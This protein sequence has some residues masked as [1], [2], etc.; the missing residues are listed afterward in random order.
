MLFKMYASNAII[1]FESGHPIA[2]PTDS[3]TEVEQPH[4]D[5]NP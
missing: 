3:R 4:R 2:N 5:T 1:K